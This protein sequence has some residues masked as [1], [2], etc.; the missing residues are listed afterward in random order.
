MTS[1]E[2]EPATLRKLYNCLF[3][4]T[5]SYLHLI[6]SFIIFNYNEWQAN[7]LRLS[8]LL[9]LHFSLGLTHVCAVGTHYIFLRKNRWSYVFQLSCPVH[10]NTEIPYYEPFDYAV[11][12]LPW[13]DWPHL[14][15]AVL[16]WHKWF[17]WCVSVKKKI[18]WARN[19]R[20][21]MPDNWIPMVVPFPCIWE[22]AAPPI[23]LLAWEVGWSTTVLKPHTLLIIKGYILQ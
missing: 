6:P 20:T 16:P 1:S 15:D 22:T 9:S 8:S 10:S 17:L 21:W 7:I 4:Y 23:L 19:V 2:I 18:K 12:Q 5:C 11:L 3:M 13:C 14:H